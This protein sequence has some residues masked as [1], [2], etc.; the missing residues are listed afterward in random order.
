MTSGNDY[1]LGR[2]Q[3]E[4][5]RLR[6]QAK[7]WEPATMRIFQQIGL[8]EGMRCLDLG[9]GPGEVMRMMGELVGATGHVTGI[10]ANG[11]IGRQAIE[12]LQATTKSH[13]TFIEQDILFSAHCL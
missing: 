3:E 1:L 12:M 13:F 7:V 6:R 10:D 9:C 8:R 5:Q 11:E 4:Y 2:T